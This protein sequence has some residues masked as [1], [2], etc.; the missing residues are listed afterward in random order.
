MKRVCL[1]IA[2]AMPLLAQKFEIAYFH[3]VDGEALQIR[4]LKFLTE[5]RALGVGTLDTESR[6]QGVIIETTDGGESW[7]LT[8]FKDIPVSLFFLNDSLGWIA[9]ES[10]VWF[11]EEG[12]R[13]WRRIKS[14]KNIVRLHFLDAQN[15]FAV[16]G[17]KQFLKTQDGG[18][19][20]VKEPEGDKPDTRTETTVYWTIAFSGRNGLVSGFTVNPRRSNLPAWMEPERRVQRPGVLVVLET[21]DNGATWSSTSAS[22]F[23][24]VTRMAMS[25]RVALTTLQFDEQFEYPGEVFRLRLG[26]KSSERV[27]REKDRLMTDVLI[28][29]SGDTY[30]A[31]Y[32]PAAKLPGVPVPGSVKIV[33]ARPREDSL[34]VWEPIEADYRAVANRVVLAE[35]PSGAIWA[36]TNTG[37]ILRLR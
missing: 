20:W 12:G 27:F 37:M 7:R 16:G 36:A 15:G 10:G 24:R 9:G 14:I 29:R 31:G 1:A 6:R 17:Q 22:I 13:T 30:L 34:L 8:P 23:G 2:L 26:Q 18:K 35:S 28:A 25:D 33:R 5:K 3:D 32:E 4:E 11:T 21:R 19:N